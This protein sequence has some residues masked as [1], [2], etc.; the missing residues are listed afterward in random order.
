MGYRSLVWRHH[1]RDKRRIQKKI[2]K[3]RKRLRTLEI[4]PP[5]GV[6]MNDEQRKI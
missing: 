1:N 2:Y 4:L 5:V 6:D 3:V